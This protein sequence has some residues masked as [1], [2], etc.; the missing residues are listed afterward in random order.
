VTNPLKNVCE[1]ANTFTW[2]QTLGSV[3]TFAKKMKM[4]K[5]SVLRRRTHMHCKKREGAFSALRLL[6]HC[7]HFEG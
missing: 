4:E 6:F 1:N 3:G 2:W 5:K 7:M